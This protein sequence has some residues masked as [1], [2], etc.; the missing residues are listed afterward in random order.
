MKGDKSDNIHGIDGIGHKKASLLIQNFKTIEGIFDN[1]SL[2]DSYYR[3]RLDGNLDYLTSM[4]DFLKV[5]PYIHYVDFSSLISHLRESIVPE[6]MG[7]FL[8]KNR[9]T[10]FS[11]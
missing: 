11:L 5:N 10:I 2:L 8:K 9:G 3:K 4:R 7:N 6:Q 1:L